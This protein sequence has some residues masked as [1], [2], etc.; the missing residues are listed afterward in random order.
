MRSGAARRWR[1]VEAQLVALA[2]LA[3]DIDAIGIEWRQADIDRVARWTARGLTAYDSAYVALAEEMQI[4]GIV[5]SCGSAGL[6]TQ[7]PSGLRARL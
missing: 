2:R 3:V 5:N 1:W 4:G 7:R 6:I